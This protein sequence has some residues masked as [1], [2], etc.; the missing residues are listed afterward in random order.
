M[1]IA[2]TTFQHLR[3]ILN[4]LEGGSKQLRRC[5]PGEASDTRFY[6]K[7]G[8]F[9]TDQATKSSRISQMLSHLGENFSSHPAPVFIQ[10]EYSVIYSKMLFQQEIFCSA[11]PTSTANASFLAVKLNACMPG[12][13][14][15]KKTV[16]F[17]M[18]IKK[19]YPIT[20]RR[21]PQNCHGFISICLLDGYL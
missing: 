5:V 4:L 10:F 14:M 13:C 3:G 1:K 11:H 19:L 12:S 8:W 16:I 21:V 6:P 15:E 2:G 20:L 17:F 18:N 9:S 7:L